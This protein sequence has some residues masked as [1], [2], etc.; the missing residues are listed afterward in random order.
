MSRKG[1]ST[2]ELVHIWL[3]CTSRNFL[4]HSVDNLFAI[5]NKMKINS[6]LIDDTDVCCG[7]VLFI[8]GQNDAAMENLKVV[9]KTLVKKNVQHLVSL[10]PGCTR[11]F[12]E[13][14]L[15][16][17]SNSLKKVEHYTELLNA[18]I[19][20]LKFTGSIK[21]HVTYH[22]PCHLARHMNIIE[23]PR[24]IIRALPGVSFTELPTTGPDAFCCG[25]GGGLRSYNKDLADHSSL[26]RLHEAA[27]MGIDTIITSCPFC[28][29]SLQSA[30]EQMEAPK[31]MKIINLIDFLPI[32]VL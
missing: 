2:D 22:D 29:R 6:K 21:K 31:K 18:H 8:T 28:E 13:Y 4:Q 15:P 12:K 7:S 1:H 3:G 20:D 9:E 11:T 16:R 19:E 5:L 14:F 32:F 17:R 30:T 27:E 24:E 26:L 25:S 23:P 10:C